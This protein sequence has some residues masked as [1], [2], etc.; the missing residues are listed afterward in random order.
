MYGLSYMHINTCIYS[1][2]WNS[3]HAAGICFCRGN[4][5]DSYA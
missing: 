5:E 3:F 1:F 4:Y 2:E